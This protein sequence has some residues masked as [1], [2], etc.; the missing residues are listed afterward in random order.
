M[1]VD[2]RDGVGGEDDEVSYYLVICGVISVFM[3]EE[4]EG[5][6]SAE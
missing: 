5:F 2:S 1:G 3:N 6:D 4:R